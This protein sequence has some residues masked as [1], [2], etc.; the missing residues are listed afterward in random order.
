ITRAPSALRE[1][2]TATV[3]SRA[4]EIVIDGV[5]VAEVG[6]VLS[7]ASTLDA[8]GQDILLFTETVMLDRGVAVAVAR[9]TRASLRRT[10]TDSYGFASGEV[11]LIPQTGLSAAFAITR[12]ELRFAD[13][14]RTKLV[15]QGEGVEVDAV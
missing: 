3:S 12:M 4:A 9:A 2:L 5:V 1:P 13:A 11:A 14:S 6:P 10:F 8:S 7:R 15:R